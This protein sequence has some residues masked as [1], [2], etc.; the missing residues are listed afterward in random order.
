MNG[1][2]DDVLTHEGCRPADGKVDARC[3]ST[4]VADEDRI[5][6][7]L[8][9]DR[10]LLWHERK[11]S[12]FHVQLPCKADGLG[13]LFF[14]FL[15]NL[16]LRT[17]NKKV[18]EALI[19]AGALDSMEGNRA[20]KFSSIEIAILFAQKYQER[21]QNKSQISLFEMMQGEGSDN[22]ADFLQYPSLPEVDEWNLQDRLNR[23]KDLL[24]F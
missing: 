11:R 23:E 15:Q 8:V 18:L 2:H 13:K 19:Q 12:R 21:E 3:G 16:D 9:A 14:E 20:Q 22:G 17:V 10:A 6:G 7:V 5:P 1:R 24:G 4:V